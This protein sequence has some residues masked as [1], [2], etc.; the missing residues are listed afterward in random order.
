MITNRK[1]NRKET[2]YIVE[3]QTYQLANFI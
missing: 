2:K 3:L 1:H